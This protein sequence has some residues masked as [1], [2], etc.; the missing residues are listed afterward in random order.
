MINS[1][2]SELATAEGSR[3]QKIL[4][5]AQEGSGQDHLRYYQTL[6]LALLLSYEAIYN[7]ALKNLAQLVI[8]LPD[9]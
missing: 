3:E 6:L 1:V 2:P 9:C 5:K 8:H 4:Y 7:I